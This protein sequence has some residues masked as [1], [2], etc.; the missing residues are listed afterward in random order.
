MLTADDRNAIQSKARAAIDK[1]TL[2]RDPWWGPPL[3]TATVLIGFV[4]YG[5]LVAFIPENY[6]VEPYLSPF[7]SP[8]LATSCEHGLIKLFGD[9]FGLSPAL[10]ILPFP[11][12]F[13]ATCYYYRRSYYRS[14][15]LSPPACGV[16]E[17]HRRYTG[18]TRFPLTIQN[19]HRYTLP[20]A[21]ILPVLLAWDGILAFRFPEGYGI[22]VGTIVL[23]VNA[24]LLGAYAVSCHS[25]RHLVGGRL[26][27]FSKSPVRYRIWKFVTKLNAKHMQLAWVSMFGV[28]LADLYVRAVAMGWITDPRIIF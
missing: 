28:V 6:Y 14:F 22:G 3:V 27:S 21:L 25:C 20:F 9:W 23:L 17:P 11:L 8:C 2:R 26:D 10:I 15:W 12:L 4:I 24:G 13:R 18:E 16:A 5:T 19:F 1:A 7:Y